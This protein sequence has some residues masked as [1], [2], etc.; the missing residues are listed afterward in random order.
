MKHFY[1]FNRFDGH[2]LTVGTVQA[3]DRSAAFEI[4]RNAEGD[5]GM[6]GDVNDVS[7]PYDTDAE[8]E[9]AYATATAGYRMIAKRYGADAMPNEA[10]YD[11]S[12]ARITFISHRVRS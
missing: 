6:Y 2:L 1:F 5:P 7:K 4:L 12:G 8:I 11:S 9:K 3:P 10:H